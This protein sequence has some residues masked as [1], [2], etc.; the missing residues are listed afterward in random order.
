ML[1]TALKLRLM[2]IQIEY[3]FWSL[4]PSACYTH[5]RLTQSY[6]ALLLYG[7]EG[8]KTESVLGL[9]VWY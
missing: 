9:K 2:L 7:Y 6:N 8:I 3:S 1:L 4:P 5:F